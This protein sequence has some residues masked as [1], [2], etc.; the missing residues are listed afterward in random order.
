M[1]LKRSR[2]IKCIKTK[3]IVAFLIVDIG[4]ISFY[5]GLKVE[6]NKEKQTIKLSQLVY[7]NKVLNK[8]Y[9]NKANSANIPMKKI[10][11]LQPRIKKDNVVT[12]AGTKIN[13]GIIRFIKFSMIE[14]KSD[15][16]FAIS[17]ASRFTKNSGHQY[18][19]AVKTIFHYLKSLKDWRITYGGQN[20]HL[21][22]KYLDSDWVKN[23]DSQKSISG[24][25]FMLNE[26]SISWC[27]KK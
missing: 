22:K 14:T 24:F 26:R 11:L 16:F 13:Q 18:T 17:V 25:V 19:K 8:F 27:S 6:R 4:S 15:I 5:F 10:T 7:I 3:L 20:K 1:A 21:V 2:F 9:L 12:I 23:K